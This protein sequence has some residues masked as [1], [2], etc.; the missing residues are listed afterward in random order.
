MLR[1][2]T[3]GELRKP[4]VGESVTLSGWVHKRRN[5]GELVFVDLRDRYGRVQVVFNKETGA[6]F[7]VVDTLKYEYVIQVEGI[8]VDRDIEAV[9]NDLKTGEIEIH[10]STVKVLNT[11]K[12]MPFE[13]FETDKG[14]EDEELRLKYRYLELRRERLKNNIILRTKMV[15]A[16]RDFMEKADFLEIETPILVKGTPEGSRE[17]LVP[18]RLYPGNFYVLPQSPQQ[19]KQLLMV[20][21]LDKYFQIARCFR[22]E[23]Q[24]GDRQPEFTQLDME[25]SFV[26][27]SDVMQLNESLM[28]DLIK[29][30]APEKKVK[31]VPFPQ[32]TYAYAMNTYGSDKPDIRFD[33]PL[34][35][36]SEK[37]KDSEFSVFKSAVEQGGVVK[38]LCVKGGAQFSRKDIDRLTD[39][40]KI[41]K[42]KGLAYLF[43]EEAGVRSPIAKFFSEEELQVIIKESGAEVGDIVL[44]AA[45]TWDIACDALG[46]V[47]L[48]VADQLG[49]RD[50]SVFA[51]C[52]V[53]DFPMFEHDE[54]MGFQAKHHPF[55]SPKNIED[56][57]TSPE[58]ALAKAYDMVLN[59]NEIGGGSIRIH[60][61]GMQ[62]RV[63]DVLGISDEQAQARFGHMLEAFEYGAPPH[64]GIAWGIDRLVMLF[65]GEP[66]I[67]EVIAFPKDQKAKDLMLG[68]PSVMPHEQLQ[69][70]S[71]AIDIKE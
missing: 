47:R 59:G 32:M 38:A 6:D 25:M 65:A 34:V 60:D 12:P 27:E 18:S 61:K 20:A 26:E 22:D 62:K 40:A 5:F 41:Y 29:T 52:W 50:D 8:V 3:C 7:A 16:I 49:L 23:D 37:V 44:F 54:T 28:L 51:L 35:D 70:L 55:T 56:M 58:K 48:A 9:N 68:A 31:E 33:L 45:D 14:E 1:T 17:Y 67:R 66:N 36:I 64:G 4:Q 24:R 69:E 15:K 2:H 71:I 11:S 63:F 21:G 19:M 39:V 10:A 53:T 46:H 13:I 42:A 43:V 57:E 30:F